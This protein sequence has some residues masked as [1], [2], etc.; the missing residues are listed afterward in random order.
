M[1]QMH[2]RNTSV[3]SIPLIEL[4]RRDVRHE[5]LPVVFIYH[6]FESSKER[7]LQHA[8]I[9]AS[10]GFFVV[11]P[12]A[13]RHGEREDSAFAALS[14]EQRV[15]FLFDI[16]TETSAE[17]DSLID[18]YS[19]Q[20][21][22]DTD[23]LG[24]IGTSMG[25]MIIYN[26]LARFGT[27]RISAA[28]PII[29]TPDFGSVIDYARENNPDLH[30]SYSDQEAE[31]VKAEQA[32]PAISLLKDF[33]LL[34]LSA[35]DDPI[36]PIAPVKDLYYRLHRQYEKKDLLRMRS[37]HNTGHETTEEMMLES[38]QWMQQHLMRN[39]VG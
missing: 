31:R 23:R 7:K 16:V 19:Q 13:V 37:Y 30:R 6:G 10:R 15:S 27:A 21:I 36:I 1:L 25:G 11:L 32:L 39:P 4:Y 18:H 17:I 8:Y 28:N 22:A 24:L 2:L 33:P 34:L 20:S 14:Y 5:H 26:Y 3:R 12:D 9:I 29:S 38:A 35:E